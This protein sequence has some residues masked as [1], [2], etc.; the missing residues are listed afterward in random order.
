MAG[1]VATG[2]G[3]SVPKV[4]LQEGTQGKTLG[5]SKVKVAGKEVGTAKGSTGRKVLRF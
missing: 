1:D 2:Q 4:D 5:K 3:R